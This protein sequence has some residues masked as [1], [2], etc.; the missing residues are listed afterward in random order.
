MR[1]KKRMNYKTKHVM[2]LLLVFAD[3]FDSGGLAKE[4]EVDWPFDEF[5]QKGEG[6]SAAIAGVRS[7]HEN[8]EWAC[9]GRSWV[10][11][12]GNNI[13]C[14]VYLVSPEFARFYNK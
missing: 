1:W 4:V 11:D 14:K 7:N 13:M 3:D 12:S 6:V 2:K 5:P 9:I 8:G 10:R